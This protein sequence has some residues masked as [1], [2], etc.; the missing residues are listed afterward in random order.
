GSRLCPWPLTDDPPRSGVAE[1]FLRGTVVVHPRSRRG[2]SRTPADG[3]P[4]PVRG[5]GYLRW[6]HRHGAAVLRGR[7]HRGHRV[8]A[9]ERDRHRSVRARLH[10]D[11]SH[12][13]DPWTAVLPA[14]RFVLPADPVARRLLG[15]A[16][17]P[18]GLDHH[19]GRSLEQP[20]TGAV[21]IEAG[22]RCVGH[23]D[24]GRPWAPTALSLEEGSPEPPRGR[25]VPEVG[26]SSGG[27][28]TC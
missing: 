4:R 25:R 11:L 15:P 7:L 28:K 9:F 23:G 17:D 27:Q 1:L 21:L 12:G 14:L 26:E 18:S 3:A 19:I 22:V 20:G 8:P 10:P 5:P 2:L 13:D 6:G 16:D 24:P